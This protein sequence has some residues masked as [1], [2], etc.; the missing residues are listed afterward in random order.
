MESNKRGVRDIVANTF[1]GIVFSVGLSVIPF[2]A[3]AANGPHNPGGGGGGPGYGIVGTGVSVFANGSADGGAMVAGKH[4][5][6]GFN[7]VF[8][9]SA[10]GGNNHSMAQTQTTGNTSGVV[11]AHRGFGVVDGS[12][13]GITYANAMKGATDSGAI[14]GANTDAMSSGHGAMATSSAGGM[15]TATAVWGHFHP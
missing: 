7:G 13:A 14:F 4:V 15:S 12:V 5:S 10:G 3:T 11:S 8:N 2:A 9:I 6:G 1:I